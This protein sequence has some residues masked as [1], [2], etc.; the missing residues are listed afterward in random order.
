MSYGMRTNLMLILS[1]VIV[2]TSGVSLAVFMSPSGRDN[3]TNNYPNPELALDI[4]D[5]TFYNSDT[6]ERPANTG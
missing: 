5:N 6:P 4:D 1:A 3:I 2:I